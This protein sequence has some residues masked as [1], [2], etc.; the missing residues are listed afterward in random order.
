MLADLHRLGQILR[1]A[2]PLAWRARAGRGPDPAVVRRTLEELGSTFIKLGQFLSL[3]VDLIPQ[4]YCGEFL[5]LLDRVPPFPFA[6][7]ERT[8]IEDLGAPPTQLF[9]AFGP[10]PFASASFGQ[11]HRAVL[12]S[13]EV[14]AVKVQ[15]PG[16]RPRL[17][18]D[19]RLL[20][21]LVRLVQPMGV[22]GAIEFLPMIEEFAAWTADELDYR[23]EA[24][25]A[26]RLR[27]AAA[28]VPDIRIPRI[29]RDLTTERVLTMEYLEGLSLA[30]IVEKIWLA[31][32]KAPEVREHYR[33]L[34][35]DL[36]FIAR[37][38]IRHMLDEIFRWNFFHADP[39]PANILLM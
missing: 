1:R 30:D 38:L 23:R 35:H 2:V 39:H 5:K 19:I 8:L 31:G 34:G 32:E 36:P 22:L 26:D 12:G 37:R 4:E 3:R 7:V 16:L 24:R 21:A 28:G 9:R 18:S 14:V 33:D 25:F 20:R 6:E 11:V 29:H 17:A 15:R 27:A 10:E 13:G